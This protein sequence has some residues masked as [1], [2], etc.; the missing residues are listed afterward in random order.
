MNNLLFNKGMLLSLKFQ[1]IKTLICKLHS[2]FLNNPKFYF[3]LNSNVI[4]N[5]IYEILFYI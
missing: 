1:E 2:L 4:V 5:I 3:I